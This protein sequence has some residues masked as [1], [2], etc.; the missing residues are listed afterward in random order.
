M[1]TYHIDASVET[2]MNLVIP[3]DR[4]A[5]RPNLDPSQR[6]A[7][8][9]IILQNPSPS[10]EKVDP[11]LKPPKYLVVSEGW[12]AFTGNPHSGVRVGKYLVLNKLTTPLYTITTATSK[13][14]HDYTS[15][16]IST[17]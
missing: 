4:V 14:L 13:Q 5:P 1:K 7:M 12:V 9:I 17:K 3:N 16:F 11:T 8:D 15:I 2:V 10:A 6:V